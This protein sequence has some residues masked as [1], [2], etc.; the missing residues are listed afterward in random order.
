LRLLG[1]HVLIE[2]GKEDREQAA[3]VPLL[4]GISIRRGIACML[5]DTTDESR[6]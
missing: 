3:N 1:S 4:K 2:P 5:R 6:R